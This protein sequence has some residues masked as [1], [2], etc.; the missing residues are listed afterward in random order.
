MRLTPTQVGY[1]IEVF[2]GPAAFVTKLAILLLLIRVFN[3][4]RGFVVGLKIIIA[5]LTLYYIAITIVKIF[6]CNPVEKFW[7]HAHPGT[8]LNSNV[9]FISDCIV[10]LITDC[11]ILV[12]PMP[13]IWALQMNFKKKLGSSFALAVG[14]M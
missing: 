14:S 5:V 4:K 2:Y 9:I 6:I 8:C 3:I 11:V 12:A 7:N 1:V 10:A 13:V